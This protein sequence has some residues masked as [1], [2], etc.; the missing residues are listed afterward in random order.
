MY[1]NKAALKTFVFSR[2]SDTFMFITFTTAIIVFN[3]TDLSVIFLKTPFLM[4]HVIYVGELALHF[5]TFFTVCLVLTGGIK[6]AQ[7]FFHV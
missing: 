1:T 6:A 3:S 5:L 4:F 7:F 2:I